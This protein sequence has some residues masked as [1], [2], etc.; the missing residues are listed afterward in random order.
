V[1]WKITGNLAGEHYLDKSR[2]PLNEGGMWAERNGFHLPNPPVADKEWKVVQGGP[3][4]GI[5]EAGIAWYV[6]R[7]DLDMPNGY[8]IPIA[9]QLP[10]ITTWSADK[11][12]AAL[13][14]AYRVQIYVNGWQFG[15]YIHHLGP[16]TKFPVPEGIWDYH[17]KNWI[18]VS[19]WAMEEGGAKLNNIKLI[20][21]P[22]IQTGYTG[23][24]KVDAPRW[25]PR[26]GVY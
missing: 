3:M 11:S 12:K 26:P 8:D 24:E 4:E 25:S 15:K 5:P 7:F 14:S 23:I 20:A 9:I 22:V 16:Q 19:L 13:A 2:G 1:T 17:G 10:N 21:G 6:T 18:A